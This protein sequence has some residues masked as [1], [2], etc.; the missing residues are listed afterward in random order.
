MT[1]PRV[2]EVRDV[3]G[4]LAIYWPDRHPCG[5]TRAEPWLI[6][7][8]YGGIEWAAELRDGAQLLD[9]LPGR[10]GPS[11]YKARG[12]REDSWLHE[13]RFAEF[14]RA[15]SYAAA[16][17]HAIPGLSK[18]SAEEA[19]YVWRII[20]HGHEFNQRMDASDDPR[21]PAPK[22]KP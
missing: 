7:H 8:D 14:R 5:A 11:V 21:F 3:G 2:G 15:Y 4:A 16:K 13:E 9:Y 12:I 20:Q 17:T 1:G 10:G 19:Y 6:L 22:E 18:I